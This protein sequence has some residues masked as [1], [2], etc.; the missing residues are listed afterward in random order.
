[1]GLNIGCLRLGMG[2]MPM[3]SSTPASDTLV[4]VLGDRL[5]IYV[6]TE[7]AVPTE[8]TGGVG[9]WAGIE[10]TG[11]FSQTASG[12]RP[13][14]VTL[15]DYSVVETSSA[16]N[17]HMDAS[18]SMTSEDD[19]TFFIV[20]ARD[21]TVLQSRRI[22]GFGT[23]GVNAINTGMIM[24]Y[25]TGPND[26]WTRFSGSSEI[27]YSIPAADA[28][29][30]HTLHVSGGAQDVRLNGVS[31]DNTETGVSASGSLLRFGTGPAN[32]NPSNFKF[33]AIA[34]V[35]GVVTG[36]ELTTCEN[37]LMTQFGI[38]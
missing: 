12:N 35:Q 28:L 22:I 13:A 24:M 3:G 31:Q 16:N 17:D 8:E 10:G 29:F 15:G 38:S 25:R 19:F 1:M 6:N 2:A 23:D 26:I 11:G 33:A 9:T 32:A 14:V 7:V 30:L 37:H 18:L 34:A 20:G 21:A 36:G 4:T 5:K 27:R